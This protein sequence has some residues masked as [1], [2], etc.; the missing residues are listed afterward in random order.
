M[1]NVHV[2]TAVIISTLQIQPTPSNTF[3]FSFQ[4]ASW[5]CNKY[6]LTELGFKYPMVFQGWQTLVGFLVL[7]LWT[8]SFLPMS[9]RLKKAITPMDK[10]GFVS[11]F[12][13]FLFFTA[14][15]ITGSKAISS[16]S[17]TEFAVASNFVPA[18]IFLI[19][20]RKNFCIQQ[21][22]S[23]IVAASSLILGAYGF[24]FLSPNISEGFYSPYFWLL[25]H[26]VC[27][28][29]ASLHSRICDA[30]FLAIDRLYYG[31]VFSFIVLAPASIYLEEAFEALNFQHR[32]QMGFLL[33]SLAGGIPGR[34]PRPRRDPCVRPSLPPW[35]W[36]LIAANLAMHLLVPTHFSNKDEEDNPQDEDD[37]DKE[38]LLA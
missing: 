2:R 4:S 31:Y 16:L 33:G 12:P 34:P 14:S 20:E 15:L 23:A 13:F 27:L 22:A 10:P 9:L 38:V 32:R 6:V 29:A 35:A 24:F 21:A 3:I 19:S 30:R 1:M 11:L 26:I 37:L 25:I 8:S 36:I 5:F 28:L 7:R 18:G 17:I